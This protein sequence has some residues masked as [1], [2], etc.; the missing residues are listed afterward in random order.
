M[1]KASIELARINKSLKLKFGL[2]IE[3]DDEKKNYQKIVSKFNYAGNDYLR[4]NPKPFVAVDISSKRDE[5]WSSNQSFNLTKP[6]LFLFKRAFYTLL[7]E[8]KSYKD[9]FYY[10]ND[11]LMYNQKYTKDI[12]KDIIACGNK[13][14]KIVPCVV[15]DEEI[16]NK[17]YE[18]C[19]LFIN[20]RDNFVY[21]TYTEMEYFY[22]CLA[23]VNM[24]EL[25]LQLINTVALF[26]N[27]ES[28]EINIKKPVTKVDDESLI[29]DKLESS[30][31]TKINDKTIPDI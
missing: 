27:M 28:E 15:Y 11:C 2:I 23:H 3:S 26:N 6:S 25:S 22:D 4:I 20:T 10:E 24:D 18:G 19:A 31:F 30:S 29:N 12:C 7:N 17:A 8:Y 14:I 21:I 9:L 1:Y 16:E 5:G 13:H